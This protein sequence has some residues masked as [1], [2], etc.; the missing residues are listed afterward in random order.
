[1]FIIDVFNV[2]NIVFKDSFN[3]FDV[4]FSDVR[5][6]VP[7]KVLKRYFDL[8]FLPLFL[9]IKVHPPKMAFFGQK[10]TDFGFS[11][12]VTQFGKK[13]GKYSIFI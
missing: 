10:L 1:M 7:T 8:L 3:I 11:D 9:G 4:L 12:L 13:L 6:V 5:L 2:S